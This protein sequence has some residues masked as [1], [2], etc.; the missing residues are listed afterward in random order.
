MK[1]PGELDTRPR[2]L[3]G[4]GPSNLH[5]RVLRAMATPA[6]GHLDPDFIA[7]MDDI[8]AMLRT[9]FGT[10][11]EM[12][13][14]V[15]GPGSAGMECCLVNLLEPGDRAV[16]CVHGVFGGRMAEVA[17]RCGAEVVRV[18]SPWG[19]GDDLDKVRAALAGG[20]TNKV[21][22]AVHGETST[23]VLQ[24]LEELSKMAREAGALFVV[25]GVATC[26]GIALAIDELGVDAFYTGSQKCLGAPAG[27]SP[28]SFSPRAMEAVEKRRTKVQSWFL[29]VGLLR[30]YWLGEKR[31]YH[32][33]APISNYFALR[34]ALRV[35]LEEG[36]AAR[37]ARHRRAHELLGEGLASLGFEFLVAP[38]VRMPM[39]NAVRLPAGLDDAAVRAR[40]LAEHDIEVG[41]GLGPLAGKIWRVGLMGEGASV[42]YVRLLVAVLGEML[43]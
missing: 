25:D 26:G 35:V 5:P 43:D 30:A 23:G 14:V 4:P 3:L 22:A 37:Y 12:T 27:L 13:F 8:Q 40:L 32:H 15:S 2:I 31:A 34:E 24:P 20:E 28:A 9:V 19:E 39:L 7:V 11:N 33:T 17:E 21:L 36:L 18:E 6:V 16:I 29:D 1:L 10:A 41:A 38:E 42:N